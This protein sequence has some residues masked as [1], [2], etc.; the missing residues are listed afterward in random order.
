[1]S[2]SVEAMRDQG[3]VARETN[4][5]RVTQ[6]LASFEPAK[7]LA[8]EHGMRL[9]NSSPGCYQLSRSDPDWLYNLYPKVNGHVPRVWV[10]PKHPSP[11][12]TLPY[13]WDLLDVVKSVLFMLGEVV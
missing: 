7:K 3:L 8:E 1:M 11:F 5:D 6:F 4:R 12:L 10:D 13:Q 9:T 2:E